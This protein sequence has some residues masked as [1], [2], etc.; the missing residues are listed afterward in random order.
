MAIKKIVNDE[1]QTVTFD[2]G[3]GAEPIVVRLSEMPAE[4]VTRLALHGISQ[5]VGDSYASA[6]KAV[7]EGEADSP[8]AYAR[9]R[10][11]DVTGLLKSGDWAAAR[12]GAGVTRVNLLVEAYARVKDCDIEQA[13]RVIDSLD[14]DQTKAAR[15]HPAIAAA[16]K[17][18]KA[19]RAAKAAE[20]AKANVGKTEGLEALGL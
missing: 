11:T 7:D 8:E 1:A 15:K 18:I 13:L 4:I 20:A 17:V 9:Q 6:A 12:E 2:F 5:K 14:E 16:M 19:E 3:D 10:V